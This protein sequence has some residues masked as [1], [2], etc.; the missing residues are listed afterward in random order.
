MSSADPLAAS[1]VGQSSA[2]AGTAG[3]LPASG[4]PALLEAVNLLADCRA[5]ELERL[6]GATG[7]KKLL[8]TFRALRAQQFLRAA[9]EKL[10]AKAAKAAEAEA[11]RQPVRK[12][13]PKEAG[14]AFLQRLA[15]D[16]EKRARNR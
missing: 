13:L 8:S 12:V 9:K 14:E 11:A 3:A 5:D 10:E 4:P 16:A 6:E 1:G 2:T 7:N 15:E